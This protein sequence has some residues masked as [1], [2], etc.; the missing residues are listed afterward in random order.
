MSTLDSGDP[1]SEICEWVDLFID[2]FTGTECEHVTV[3]E[4]S[5]Y[6]WKIC[7]RFTN[8]RLVNHTIR[9]FRFLT[10]LHLASRTEDYVDKCLAAR[11]KRKVVDV[12]RDLV[13]ELIV[14]RDTM[15]KQTADRQA[16][17]VLLRETIDECNKLIASYKQIIT[18]LEERLKKAEQMSDLS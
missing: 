4:T 2:K 10:P 8:D 6:A 18:G 15:R 11:K 7:V 3:E 17:V 14:L 9:P 5:S 12:P 13:E 16:E 1:P